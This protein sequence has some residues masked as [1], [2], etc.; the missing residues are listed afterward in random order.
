MEGTTRV[1]PAAYASGY[2]ARDVARLL[3]LTIPQISGLVRAG[4]LHPQR[5]PRGEFRFSFQDL[6]LLRTAKDLIARM[7]ARRVHRALLKLK[8]QLPEGRQLA[9]LRLTA[10][11]EDIVVRDGGRDRKSV[12]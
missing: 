11:G 5:G 8:E 6:V 10:E 7:P 1:R 9:A 12:V 3:G 4:C 2:P